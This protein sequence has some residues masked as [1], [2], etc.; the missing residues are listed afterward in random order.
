MYLYISVYYHRFGQNIKP[1]FVGDNDLAPEPE[2]IIEALGDD[3]EGDT[4][5][6]E[7]I[8][9]FGPFNVPEELDY[10]KIVE[11]FSK[12]EEINVI[13]LVHDDLVLEVKERN[14]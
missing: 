11:E 1:I 3:W 10:G 13:M 14:L 8:D 9:I 2:D 5:D 6:D 4:R 12:Q 7:H